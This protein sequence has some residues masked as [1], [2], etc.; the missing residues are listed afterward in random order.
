M[1]GTVS[2]DFHEGVT[3]LVA[4]E[5]GSKKYL[6]AANLG[7]KIMQAEWIDAL[8]EASASRYSLCAGV[9][10]HVAKCVYSHA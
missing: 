9:R 10:G 3:H 7:K 1:M 2:K 8:L 4:G 5:V 6:V